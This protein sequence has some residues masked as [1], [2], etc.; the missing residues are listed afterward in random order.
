MAP[1]SST[2]VKHTFEVQ[3]R[4][5]DFNFRVYIF[6]HSFP[7]TMVK[8]LRQCLAHSSRG[9]RA[10]HQ[11]QLSSALLNTSCRVVG[12]HVKGRGEITKQET[13]E[14]FSSQ[15]QVFVTTFYREVTPKDQH[16]L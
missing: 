12:T 14:Q 5:M 2:Q 1:Q 3:V 11:H 10:Q 9:S 8:Y 7:V 6:L 13:R 4:S 15:T 16:S